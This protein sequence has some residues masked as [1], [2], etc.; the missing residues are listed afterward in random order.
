MTDEQIRRILDDDYDPSRENGVLSMIRDFYSRKMLSIII[1][2][3]FWAILFVAGAIYC[4]VQFAHADET[5]SQIMYASLFV[6]FVEG[7][8]LMKIFAWQMI[9][10]NALN[11]EIKRLELRI[12]ALGDTIKGA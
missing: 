5:K 9:V 11:R 2:V 7:I 10:K 3:W 1:L 4:G 12:A 6:V 8:A